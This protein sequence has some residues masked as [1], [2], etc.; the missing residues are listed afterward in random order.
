[1]I[2]FIKKLLVANRG[3]I[4]CRILRTAKKLGVETVA[5]HSDIDANSKFVE[6]ADKAYRVGPNPSLESYL[7]SNKIIDICKESGC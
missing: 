6:M 2:R 4:A 5:I 7:N 1:M 3:E